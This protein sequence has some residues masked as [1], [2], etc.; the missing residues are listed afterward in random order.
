VRIRITRQ[1]TGTVD[2]IDLSRFLEGLTYEVGTTLGSYLLAQEWAEPVSHEAPAAVLPLNRTIHRPS[3]LIVEDDEDMRQI[4]LQLL[5]YHGWPAIAASDGVEALEAL[6]KHRPSLIL[7]DL[8][9]PRMN[10][11]Q[12]R[13]AQRELP[14]KR[15]ANVPV[16]LVSAVADAPQYKSTLNAADVLVKPFEAD[17]LLQAVESHVRPVSLFRW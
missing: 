16:V 7:L 4:L 15:L 2:G 12:F 10:G 8:A 5:D 14:D 11:I 3:V 9:M 6:Q 1:P 13:T 17:R